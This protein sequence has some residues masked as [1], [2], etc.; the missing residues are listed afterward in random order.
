M[1]LPS[2]KSNIKKFHG[3]WNGE[4]AKHLLKRTTFGARKEDIIFFSSISLTHA[5]DALLDTVETIPAPPLNHY[6]DD[7]YTD[8]EITLGET[9]VKAT[10]QQ[11]GSGFRRKNS[12][13]AW[14][15]GLQLQQD[16]LSV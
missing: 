16:S 14:W 7:K 13:K 8:P 2:V 5:V 3:K 9:W 10:K 12:L 6:N 1:Q 4:Q 11:G 15:T